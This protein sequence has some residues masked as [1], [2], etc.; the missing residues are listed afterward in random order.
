MRLSV[1]I[2]AHNQLALTRRC[3]RAL[4]IALEGIDHEVYCVDN[5]SSDDVSTLADEGVSFARFVLRRNAENRPFSL[6]N[7]QV[8]LEA[9]G[10][11]VLFLNNDVE[12]GPAS[13]RVLLDH[14]EQ[15]PETGVAG[16]R[17]VYPDSN[18]LQHAGMEQMLWGLASNFG[19][20]AARND[21]RFC[22]DTAR[23]AV[24]GAM[25]CVRR[26]LFAEV[27]GFEETFTWGYEDVDLCLK[28][29][30]R[31]LQVS[32]VAAAEAIHFESATLR[33]RH[34]PVDVSRNYRIYR[35]RWNAVLVPAEAAYLKWLED[36]GIRRVAIVGTGAAGRALCQT[37]CD[38]GITVVAFG[39]SNPDAAEVC[40]R[41]VVA[42]PE[43]ER[44]SYDRLIVG[45]QYFFEIESQIQRYDPRGSPLF[46]VVTPGRR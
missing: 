28:V 24:T 15:H 39:A 3:L 2:L 40:G 4:A 43:L 16:G 31:G 25:L 42:L 13:L 10:E 35:Q 34:P 38:G 23:F 36:C 12:V 18:R 8:A 22:T 11:W 45:S 9:T 21:R 5:A 44:L 1:I 32:Y 14:L 27:G 30:S 19:V 7:N 46:P 29:R 6:A 20:G 33:H 17:L 41:P 37:L 26:R